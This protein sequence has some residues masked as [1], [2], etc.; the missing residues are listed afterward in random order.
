MKRKISVVLMV[1]MIISFATIVPANG[2]TNRNI[3]KDGYVEGYFIEYSGERVFIE[4]Y[5]GRVYGIPMIRDVVL[6]IDGR[7]IKITDFKPGMEIYAELQGRS[8]KHMDAFSVDIPGYIQQ[9]EKARVGVVKK[10]DRDQIQ[11]KLPT[12]KEET[13][14]TSPATIILRN[15]ENVNANSLYVGDSVKLYFDETNSSYISRLQIEGN[16]ITIK[17]L[18]RGRITVVDALEDIL[19]LEKVDVFKN[20]SWKSTD[21]NLR[22]PYNSDLPIYVGGQKINYKNLKHYKGKTVYMAMKDDFGKEKIERMVVKAQY[23]SSFSDKIKNINWF[24]S[25]LELDN[26]KN[27]NFHEGTMVIKSGRL[28]DIHNLNSKSD[29]MVIADGRGA[30]L[31]ADLIY[32]YNEDINNSNVGQDYIYAGRLDTILQDKLHLR[33]FFLL[34]RNEWE[35]F[36][37][38]KELYYDEDTF[39]YDME[40][41]KEISTKEFF[42]SK[43]S[44][45]ED[46]KRDRNSNS[47]RKSRDWYGYLYTD[48]DQVSAAFVKRSL[49]SLRPQRTTIGVVENSPTENRS[50][51]WTIKLRD[52][53]DWSNVHEEWMA[54][55]AYLDLYLKEAMIIK[56]GK[57][58][59]ITDI[60]SGDRLYLVRD[61]S[62]AKVIIIK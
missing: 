3:Y 15:K 5:G 45:D 38:Q 62:M 17:D 54:Q 14:F 51:G 13:Y 52:A 44:V 23:E 49:D 46:G 37:D 4:E 16:S 26:N 39:I 19:S 48:G 24:S 53:K 50:M 9:E 22:V 42:S 43:F 57:R 6:E 40:N 32:I 28:V 8:I 1:M 12:G 60:K 34:E 56:N 30:D 33:D 20:G 61:S 7:P 2:A 36:S 41:G 25:Q 47:N 55:N 10:I 31:T 35:S 58:A 18:Y 27:I 11:I 21:M 59:K 29:G